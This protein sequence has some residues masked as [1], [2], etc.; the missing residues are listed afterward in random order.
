MQI[1]PAVALLKQCFSLVSTIRVSSGQ[2]WLAVVSSGRSVHTR[3]SLARGAPSSGGMRIPE[4]VCIMPC[5]VFSLSRATP[6]GRSRYQMSEFSAELPT[7]LPPSYLPI[8]SD[9][10]PTPRAMRDVR[11]ADALSW[12]M[13]NDKVLSLNGLES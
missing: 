7:S 6:L 5:P 1:T 4:H 13:K 12:T 8:G 3:R 9:G 2:Q 11:T 10:L